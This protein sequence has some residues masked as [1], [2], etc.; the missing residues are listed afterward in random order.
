MDGWMDGWM[1]G[2]MDAWMHV[3]MYG[4]MY[5]CMYMYV[6]NVCNVCM[7]YVYTSHIIG[8]Y[9]N[10][11]IIWLFWSFN[12]GLQFPWIRHW[13]LGLPYPLIPSWSP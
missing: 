2:C 8:Y 1:H 10:R 6:C 12:D 9:R 4:C 11:I 5:A 13:I 3:C 7:S